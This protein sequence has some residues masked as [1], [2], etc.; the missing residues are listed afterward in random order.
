MRRE[1]PHLQ[2]SLTLS[3]LAELVQS[4]SH[5]LSQVLNESLG[6]SFHEYLARHRVEEAK[7]LLSGP[8][9]EQLRIEDLAERVGYY[10]KSSFNNAFRRLTGLTPSQFRS[11]QQ[12]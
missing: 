1:R 9:K 12:A 6:E 2:P 8:E 11:S 4:S 3:E 10:S 7:R 5:H